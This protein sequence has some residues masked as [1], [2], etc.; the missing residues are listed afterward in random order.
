MLRPACPNNNKFV[1]WQLLIDNPWLSPIAFL[2][3]CATDLW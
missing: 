3:G 1:L 2:S